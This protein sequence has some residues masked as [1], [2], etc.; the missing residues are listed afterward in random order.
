MNCEVLF[1]FFLTLFYSN[2]SNNGASEGVTGGIDINF[3]M[4]ALTIEVKRMFRAESRPPT[5]VSHLKCFS[6]IG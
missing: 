6:H 3:I 2:M 5:H 4:E 1:F